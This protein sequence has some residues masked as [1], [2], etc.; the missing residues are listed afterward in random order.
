MN[1]GIIVMLLISII[2]IGGCTKQ[3][4]SSEIN[5]N[6]EDIKY[7]S[8]KCNT[9]NDCDNHFIEHTCLKCPNEK[10]VISQGCQNNPLVV[11]GSKEEG[12]CV[13]SDSLGQG[14]VPGYDPF[15]SG[16]CIPS[17]AF[18]LVEFNGKEIATTDVELKKW[19]ILWKELLLNEQNISESY[20]KNHVLVDSFYTS[21]TNEGTIF[22]IKYTINIDW[23][24][25]IS[26]DGF[27]IRNKNETN[28]LT[29]NEVYSALDPLVGVKRKK[30]RNGF[31]KILSQE[32]VTSK[33]KQCY[34]GI[35]WSPIDGFS[36]SQGSLFLVD[37]GKLIV[38]AYG[39]IN[40]KL[41]ECKFAS[42][43]LETGELL[44]CRDTA[45]WIS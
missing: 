19:F 7:Y 5:G 27:L 41:N 28:Y 36:T 3:S 21:E 39:T 8:H 37:E 18:C 12:V 30:L 33:L 35:K 32:E 29:I 16:E 40:E 45:C 42:L 10:M 13:R 15:M 1:K 14:Y 24:N 4:Y 22:S 9:S 43:D 20:F 38:N 6:F 25:I 44:E 26:G 23:A 17:G 2:L 31:E 34:E 11:V